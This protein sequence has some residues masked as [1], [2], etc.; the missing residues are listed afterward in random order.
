[1]RI[2][3]S[4][5]WK[6]IFKSYYGYFGYQI[7]FFGLI[8]ALVTFRGYINKILVEK[9]DVFDIIYPNDILIYTKNK[10]KEYIKVVPW[11]LKQI[12]KYLL[13]AILKKYQFYQ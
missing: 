8:N 5:K 12:Q 3:E 6:T 13:Y 9:L 2:R 7:I 10:S 4:N 1:M 11:I